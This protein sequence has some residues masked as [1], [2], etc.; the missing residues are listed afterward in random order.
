MTAALSRPTTSPQQESAVK[1][2]AKILFLSSSG[3][4]SETFMSEPLLRD[5]KAKLPL[6]LLMCIDS[7]P[8]LPS[9]GEHPPRSPLA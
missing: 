9:H 3:A 5:F 2:R 4:N 1:V 8:N 7:H 6:P